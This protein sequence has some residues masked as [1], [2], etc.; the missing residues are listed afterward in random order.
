MTVVYM[1][2]ETYEVYIGKQKIEITKDEVID[3]YDS[4]VMAGQETTKE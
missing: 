3:L 1:G 4:I 2:N